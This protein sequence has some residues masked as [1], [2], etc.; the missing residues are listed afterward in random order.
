L[1]RL[2][3]L[4]VAEGFNQIFQITLSG[5]H[6]WI[7]KFWGLISSIFTINNFWNKRGGA[8]NALEMIHQKGGERCRLLAKIK[9]RKTSPS[10]NSAG[11]GTSGPNGG[12]SSL[13]ITATL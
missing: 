8:I 13:E 11:F 9:S 5:S 6:V 7:T 10:S 12:T 2:Q 3:G 4:G 1:G